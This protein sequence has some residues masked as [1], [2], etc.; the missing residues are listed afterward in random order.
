[1]RGHSSFARRLAILPDGL[2]LASL[3][4][5]DGLLKIWD[6]ESG[7]ELLSLAAHEGGGD[8]LTVSPDG[9]RIATSGWEG[10]VRIWD[11]GRAAVDRERRRGPA[12]GQAP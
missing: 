2:R 11:A 6:L 3:G 10:S 12:L 5:D 8:G 4:D 9:D 7:Q 1:L